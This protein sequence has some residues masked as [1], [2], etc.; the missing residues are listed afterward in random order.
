M[1]TKQRFFITI[2]VMFPQFSLNIAS[3]SNYYSVL[4]EVMA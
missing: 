4:A 3:Q 2:F 1:Q